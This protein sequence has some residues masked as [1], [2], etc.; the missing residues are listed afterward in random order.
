[1]R[2]TDAVFKAVYVVTFLLFLCA[3]EQK[4]EDYPNG[5]VI[6]GVTLDISKAEMIP[7]ETLQLN[8]MLL[9]FNTTVNE[10][11]TWDDLLRD[12]I[13]WRSDNPRVAQVNEHGL[14]TAK[15]AGSCNISFICGTF[16]AKCRVSVCSFDKE[17]VYG[18]WSIE[19][20]R[21]KYYFGF[22]DS[23]YMNDTCIFDWTFDGMRLSV[24]FKGSNAGQANRT[25][26]LISL[27]SN[28]IDFFFGDDK[29]KQNMKMKRTPKSFSYEELQ[30]GVVDK[31][32]VSVVDLGL[33]SGTIW[34]VCN[35]GA[36]LPNQDGDRFAWA[37]TNTKQSYTLENYMYYDKHML[38]ITKYTDEYLTDL[39]PD[40]DPVTSSLGEE[41]HIPTANQ[42]NE[43]FDNCHLLYSVVSGKEG[44]VLVPQ[45]A[46]YNDRRLFLPFSM[47]SETNKRN[48]MSQT[49]PVYDKYGFFWTS[50]LSTVD[51]LKAYTLCINMD[52]NN[53]QLYK[54][55]GP[56]HRYYGLCIRPVFNEKK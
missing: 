28:S 2:N 17:I 9:P 26:V 23:G 34:A 25:M 27:N 21:D 16:S 37:E 18:L 38:R 10:A 45:K 52:D 3:C 46:E 53:V 4:K 8:A 13:F 47:T 19:N 39:L 20:S 6:E 12:L 54:G 51:I 41:W 30:S 22:D 44:F 14:V 56:S 15:E 42:V 33:P 50:T 24:D 40:D 1:M 48:N 35:L 29:E 36:S 7:G 55:V 5:I 43:L 31:Q 49:V 32:G 11:V